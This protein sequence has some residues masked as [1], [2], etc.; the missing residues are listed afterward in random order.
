MHDNE[1]MYRTAAVAFT[2]A[3][4]MSLSDVKQ[5]RFV[6]NFLDFIILKPTF[7]FTKNGEKPQK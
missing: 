5:Q 6:V 1:H 7:I 3:G 2:I 4:K